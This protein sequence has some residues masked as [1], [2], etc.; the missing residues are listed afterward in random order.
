LGQ[1]LR[2][3]DHVWTGDIFGDK[4][5]AIKAAMAAPENHPFMLF[6]DNG[7]K[8]HEFQTFVPLLWPGDLVAVHDAMNEFGENDAAPV[9]KLV[10]RAFVAEGKELGTLTW[11]YRRL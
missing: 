4:L 10:E 7:R 9:G 6:C 11:F 1:A 2:L 5:P 8:P 3:Q